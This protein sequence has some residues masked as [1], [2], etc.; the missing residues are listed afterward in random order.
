MQLI[1]LFRRRAAPRTAVADPAPETPPPSERTDGASHNLGQPAAQIVQQT[2][3]RVLAERISLLG[4]DRSGA[5]EHYDLML[6]R[7]LP[8]PPCD[9]A[10]IDLIRRKLPDLRSYHEIGSGLGSLPFMLALEG[11]A[12]VGVERDER[13]HLTSTAILAELQAQV[14]SIESNCRLIWAPFPDAVADMDLSRSMAI[15]TDFVATHRPAELTRLYA[16]LGRYQF[17]LVDLQRFC[18]KRDAGPGQ[19]EVTDLLVQYGLSPCEEVI[20]LGYEGY[21]RLF[22]GR[23]PPERRNGAMANTKATPKGG[24]TDAVLANREIAPAETVASEAAPATAAP[25]SLVPILPPMPQRHTRQRFGGG[26]GISAAF[27]IGIPML[28]AVAYYFLVAANQYV[29][30]FEFVVRGP[31]QPRH[32]S[33]LFGM[34]GG[35]AASPDAFVVTDFINSHQSFEDTEK[36]V[37]L[38]AMF[39][40]PAADF[41]TRL[42]PN[43][44]AQEID[45][46][47]QQ[48]VVAQ[49]DPISG[50]ISVS[51]RAFA[52]EDSLHLAQTLIAKSDAMFKRLNSAAQRSY[53]DLADAGV[54]RAEER[55]KKARQ[56][57]LKLRDSIGVVAPGKVALSN[58][59]IVDGLRRQLAGLVANY[60]ATKE[61]FPQSPALKPL[62][63]RITTLEHQIK[64]AQK[65][66]ADPEI[67]DSPTPAALGRYEE[68]D[69]ERQFAEKQYTEALS[70]REQAYL[71]AQSQESYLA[72]FVR[73]TLTSIYPNRPKAVAIVVLAAAAAWFFSVLIVYAVRDHLM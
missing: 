73:P 63:S 9:P 21:Y 20:D 25:Q 45:S 18:E 59:E 50:N 46:Y 17:V 13:R 62:K 3:I 15:L 5:Y 39:G 4:I 6:Q 8:I 66:T 38:R 43:A 35:T 40:T 71:A 36:D 2:A 57:L 16:A 34:G 31:N 65:S 67:M 69:L 58:S 49:F 7:G 27:M 22:E 64:A 72:L 28:M 12:A 55:L 29:T 33:S 60:N 32:S 47:W 14:P 48:M 41:L 30:T 42:P 52:P 68:L 24:Q 61:S 26:I 19:E 54:S 56:A 51:V 10:I 1:S 11:F 70:T 44:S 53:V 23:S 37:N